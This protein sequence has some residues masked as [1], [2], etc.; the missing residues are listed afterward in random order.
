MLKM[1]FLL[2]FPWCKELFHI[3]RAILL[4]RALARKSA[5]FLNILWKRILTDD[6]LRENVVPKQKREINARIMHQIR[7]RLKRSEESSVP[8]SSWKH[9]AS[10][11]NRGIR[12]TAEVQWTRRL[13]RT[14]LSRSASE[15]IIH[16]F[17][18]F[19]S[20]LGL[21]CCGPPFPARCGVDAPYPPKTSVYQ[22][23]LRWFMKEDSSIKSHSSNHS[24]AT[25]PETCRAF[26]SPSAPSRTAPS[27]SIT[28]AAI[29]YVSH[30]YGPHGYSQACG[31]PCSCAWC[32][33]D[34]RDNLGWPRAPWRQ[35]LMMHS[36]STLHSP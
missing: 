18:Q 19:Q 17:Y 22:I 29:C 16:L 9:P 13:L 5:A 31:L 11:L 30:G 2:S 3:S 6:G 21:T 20:W 28:V 24:S 36:R 4:P 33:H 35:W 15:N 25:P 26:G 10:A 27:T 1:L 7:W 8:I 23:I 32:C 12:V 14:M 34:S